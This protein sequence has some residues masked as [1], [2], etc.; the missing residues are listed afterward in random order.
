MYVSN[1]HQLFTLSNHSHVLRKTLG[2]Y[3]R[4]LHL[5]R[6]SVWPVFSP[7]ML[8]WARILFVLWYVAPRITAANSNTPLCETVEPR[9]DFCTL[10]DSSWNTSYPNTF[11]HTNYNQASK[12][13]NSFEDLFESRCS[14]HLSYFLCS[15]IF[16]FCFPQVSH[17][18]EPCQELCV[19]VR[20]NCTPFLNAIGEEWPSELDCNRFQPHGTNICVWDS[21][22]RNATTPSKP[23]NTESDSRKILPKCAGQLV[24]YPNFSHTKFGGIDNCDESCNGIYLNEEEQKFNTVWMAIWSLL[25]LLVS[26]ITCLTRVLNYK[27]VKSP[28]S[29]VYN[30]ALSY[31]FIA[32][33]Y[34]VS[35]ALGKER[36]ICDSELKNS[37][38]ESALVVDGLQFPWCIIQF[39]IT[40]LFT[41]SNWIWWALLNL[42]WL[43]CSIKSCTLGLK[44]RICSHLVGW[45]VPVLFLLIA[46]GTE[47]VGG[48]SV[49]RTCWVKKYKEVAYLIG[50][51]L[52][53][54]V[55]SCVVIIMALSRVTKLQRLF[56]N[57]ELESEEVDRI[58][59]L[60]QVCLYSTIYLLAM[61]ILLCC[62][63]Y[64]HCYRDKWERSYID[65]LNKS[66]S[67]TSQQKPIFNILKMKFAV[68]LIM[69]IV[70]GAWVFRNSSTRAWRKVCCLCCLLETQS[71]SEGLNATRQLQFTNE[72]YATRF[73][74]SE[75]SV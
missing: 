45:G 23:R 55:F 1:Y 5:H 54:I 20:E 66:T 72:P 73:S 53:V 13:L 64:E 22:S 28:E 56:K 67:C 19:T 61:G 31:F 32:F 11:N 6:Y 74:F 46:L 75:T 2:V 44:W 21:S 14:I 41:M 68:S 30:I 51:L 40:Y 43:I 24:R 39:S 59:M 3:T 57:T 52:T 25:C 48:N 4:A 26:V 9:K 69:G 15:A 27:A 34:A 8:C 35:L 10:H 63:L 17:R 37:L 12:F 60:N 50:P 71:A 49:L 29:P 33:S 47:S 7:A 58:T 42:E 18:V 70:S 36:I 16:P 65:C 62:Y 38:D